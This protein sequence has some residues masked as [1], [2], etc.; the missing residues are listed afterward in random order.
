MLLQKDIL[1]AMESPECWFIDYG[2]RKVKDGKAVI[3]IDSIHL[4]T[5]NTDYPYKGKV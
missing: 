4:E 2:E 3:K 1:N 5:I